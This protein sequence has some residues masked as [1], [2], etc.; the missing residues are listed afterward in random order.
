MTYRTITTL[1]LLLMVM[2]FAVQ[3]TSVVELNFLF[4]ELNVPRWLL[5]FA[6]LVTGIVIGWFL[7]AIS[8]PRKAAQTVRKGE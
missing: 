2:L 8:A 7:H 3:N 1:I 6:V 4:W 5:I